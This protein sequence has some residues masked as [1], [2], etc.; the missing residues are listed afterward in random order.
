MPTLKNYPR[1]ARKTVTLSAVAGQGAVGTV[2]LFTVQ[3]SVVIERITALCTTLLT[4]A[5]A[6]VEV[7]VAGNTAALIAQTTGTDIDASEF[8]QDATPE[9]GVSPAI[10]EKNVKGNIILTV[11]TADV[12]AGVIEFVVFWRPLST[13]GSLAAA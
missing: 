6:T 5:T 11:A 10:V 13:D 8:W 12:T 3:G 4:G 2:A 7:G 1:V 9:A